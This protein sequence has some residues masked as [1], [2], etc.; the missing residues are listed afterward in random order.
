MESITHLIALSAPFKRLLLLVYTVGAE[1]SGTEWRARDASTAARTAHTM[2]EFER[3]GIGF[4][5]AQF[6]SQ[7]SPISARSRHIFKT[8]FTRIRGA[9]VVRLDDCPLLRG[10]SATKLLTKASNLVE[11]FGFPPPKLV[12]MC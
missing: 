2:R 9:F 1:L 10:F 11:E 5:T 7:Y 6:F 12:C 4:R 3:L 8:P